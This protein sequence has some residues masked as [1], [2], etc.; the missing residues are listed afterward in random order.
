MIYAVG[1]CCIA[2]HGCYLGSR[3]VATLY[4]L[5]L[6][7]T[8][9][10]VGVL[11][12]LYA[13]FS[14]LLAI[15]AGKLSDRVG[16]RLPMIGGCLL[17][18]VALMIAYL[19]PSMAALYV[20]AAVIGAAFIFFNVAIQNLVGL[21]SD[22]STRAR[23]FSTLSQGYSISTTLSPLGA[24]FAVDHIG[25]VSTYLVF[26]LVS[27]LPAAGLVAMRRL[28]SVRS[29]K[30]SDEEGGSFTELLRNKP[31]RESFISSGLIVTAWDV[32]TFYF[33]VHGHSI[34]MSATTIGVVLSVFGASAFVARS[35]MPM[36][37]RRWG[38]TGLLTRALFVSAGWFV[39]FPLTENTYLLA[40]LSAGL[41]LT[42]GLGQPLSMMITYMR[43]PKGRSGEANGI[44]LMVN[45]F[46]HFAV[47]IV[48]G[49]LGT[50]FGVG[51]VFWI[52]AVLLTG[53]GRMVRRRQ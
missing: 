6:G 44:R 15:Y 53:V 37:I 12:G 3:L 5:E 10:E 9:L 49:A 34:G 38:E 1:L 11:G 14:L 25:P 19:V 8:P 23:N 43:S 32:Y 35:F 51:P 27:L 7:A 46:T 17:T 24:G 33:P 20:S 52:N 45:H 4:A 22:A 39:L 16:P 29:P 2:I 42:L 13:A 26:A 47:P 30:A 31:L 28:A 18:F 40:V 21:I 41:G 48:S 36:L 50:A